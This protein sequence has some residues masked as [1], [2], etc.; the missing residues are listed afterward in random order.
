VL[1]VLAGGERYG[2]EL[3]R[4]LEESSD[5]TFVLKE[6][7]LYPLLHALE[8]DGH[9]ESSWVGEEGTRQRKYYRITRSGRA[10][11]GKKREEWATFRDAVNQVLFGKRRLA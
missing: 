2:Y 9:V 10:L 11:L 8:A 5:G 6:G 4:E 7:T 1:N 3:I